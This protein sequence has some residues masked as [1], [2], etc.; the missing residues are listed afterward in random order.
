MTRLPR[1][2]RPH[3]A[4]AQLDELCIS[5]ILKDPELENVS[6]NPIPRLPR[7]ARVD[8]GQAVLH[9]GA[10]CSIEHPFLLGTALRRRMAA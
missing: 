8:H 7:R 4:T 9:A 1:A 3:R 2:D 5:R 10:F 6:S